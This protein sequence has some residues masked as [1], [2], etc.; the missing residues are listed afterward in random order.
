MLF[1]IIITCVYVMC[2][3]TRYVHMETTKEL[4]VA[5]SLLW[6]PRVELRLQGLCSKH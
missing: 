1:T 5:G 4:L 6:N 2:E 3:S